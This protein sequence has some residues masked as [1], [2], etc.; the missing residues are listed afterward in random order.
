MSESQGKS[1][2]QFRADLPQEQEVVRTTIVGGRPPGSGQRLGPIPRG[3]EVLVR[4][5]SVDPEFK[6]AKKR[7]RESFTSSRHLHA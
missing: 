5:A 1:G 3:I 7:G 6:R 2:P 4:K